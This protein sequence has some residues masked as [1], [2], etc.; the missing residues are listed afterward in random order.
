MDGLQEQNLKELAASLEKEL[1]AMTLELN[2]K[3]R[4]LEVQ[5]ALDEVRIRATAMRE[6]SELAETSSVLFHQL[7]KLEI[8]AI[9]TGVGIFDDP[10]D[11]MELWLTAYSDSQEV[12]QILDYINLRIH[13]VFENIIP[14]RQQKKAF[15]LTMREGQEVRQYYQTMSTYISLRNRLI[16]SGNDYFFFF[17]QGAI[18]VVTLQQLSEEEC[19]IV[20]RFLREYRIDLYQV[21]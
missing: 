7:K 14:A 10:Y 11:A 20:T 21:S 2:L 15:A 9:R 12:I 13:P 18:N 16:M 4:E 6:S 19:D 5:D 3:N 17:N 8:N 1:A